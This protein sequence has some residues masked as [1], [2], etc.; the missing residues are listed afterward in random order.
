[1]DQGRTVQPSVALFA[2]L[3]PW[4][5]IGGHVQEKIL[6]GLGVTGTKQ[7]FYRS[8]AGWRGYQVIVQWIV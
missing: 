4:Q 5:K 2:L 1:M 7:V 8:V 3:L 6:V